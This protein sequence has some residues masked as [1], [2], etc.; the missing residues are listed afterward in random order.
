[1][2]QLLMIFYPK[3]PS[4]NS[5]QLRKI[6]RRLRI[7]TEAAL[8]QKLDGIFVS[9]P[10]VIG[11]YDE[12]IEDALRL[13]GLRLI[14]GHASLSH[15]RDIATSYAAASLGLVSNYQDVETCQV[16]E[17]QLPLSIAISITFT[18]YFLGATVSSMIR[19]NAAGHG[20]NLGQDLFVDFGAGLDRMG[21]FSAPNFY[22]LHICNR[23]AS[24]VS[25][26]YCKGFIRGDTGG[27]Y[28]TVLVTG[29]CGGDE[30]FLKILRGVLE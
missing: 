17:A 4:S 2:A 27:E 13:E 6:F 19:A 24:V 22:W 8:G 1:M 7:E 11:L 5:G 15:Q 20:D 10:P 18:R 28:D 23:L 26:G 9:K 16:E 3:H 30:R 21:S 12:D 29:E 14:K 25:K